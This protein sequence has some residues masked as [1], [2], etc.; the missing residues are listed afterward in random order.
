MER[1]EWPSD[2]KPT[3]RHGFYG[4]L[5][6]TLNSL[7]AE[8]SD[9]V[10][11]SHSTAARVGDIERARD[12]EISAKDTIDG[13]L[14]KFAWIAGILLTSFG[15]V[16]LTQLDSRNKAEEAEEAEFKRVQEEHTEAIEA[17]RSELELFQT[18]NIRL[19]EQIDS[20]NE[21]IDILKGEQ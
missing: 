17:L 11:F 20:K 1:M 13:F 2:D 5:T 3:T 15:T 10:E 6:Q 19:N 9:L 16:V 8:N 18:M 4:R 12:K 14:R 7:C 21:V